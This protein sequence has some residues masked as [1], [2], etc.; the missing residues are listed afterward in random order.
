MAATATT[1]IITTPLI[2]PHDSHQLYHHPITTDPPPITPP[3]SSPPTDHLHPRS[4][5]TIT[6]AATHL[7]VIVTTSLRRHYLHPTI[8]TMT[9]LP[10]STPTREGAS[11]LLINTVRVFVLVVNREEALGYV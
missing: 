7:A 8:T 4:T 2:T 1:I 5:S 10:L 9:Q 3:R 6:K 11:G